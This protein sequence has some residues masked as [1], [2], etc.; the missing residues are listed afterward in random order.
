MTENEEKSE[1]KIALSL[2]KTAF[3]TLERDFQEVLMELAGKD[4]L[5]KFKGEYEK[6]HRTLL[7]AHENEKRLMK[8]CE[9]LT[10]EII[11]NA[12]K[13]QTA[14]NLSKED[15]NTISILKRE[16]DK[17]WKLIN[18][19][20]EKEASAKLTIQKL[21]K[22]I[23]EL[24]K[25]VN[26]GGNNSTQDGAVFELEKAKKDLTKERDQKIQQI[27]SLTN[28]M[29]NLQI[30]INDFNQEKKKYMITIESLTDQLN[31][32]RAK[33][34]QL[35]KQKEKSDRELKESKQLLSNKNQELGKKEIEIR[36]EQ[37]KVIEA[38]KRIKELETHVVN[39]QKKIEQLNS[40]LEQSL[41]EKDLTERAVENLKGDFDKF[42]I[43][44]K[45]LENKIKEI[46]EEKNQLHQTYQSLMKKKKIVELERDEI[47]RSKSSLGEEINRL[48]KMIEE[49]KKEKEEELENVDK[50]T[51]EKNYLSKSL[52][53]LRKEKT[54]KQD[55]IKV[56][57]GNN[58]V[59]SNEVVEERK[60]TEKYRQ[61]TYSLEKE[62]EKYATDAA[63]AEQRYKM[64]L[65]EVKIKTMEC[66]ELQKKIVDIQD[67]LKQQQTLYETIRSERNAKSK[68]LIAAYEESEDM[69]K[70]FKVMQQQIDQLK[71]EITSR[72]K[73]LAS[74]MLHAKEKEKE[75]DKKMEEV[76]LLEKKH[77]EQAQVL[78]AHE[79]ENY[80][81]TQ[82][83]LQSDNERKKQKKDY[84]AV[85]S[86]R[87]VL[88]TQLIRRND[89]IAL[90]YEK[91][92]LQNSTL[93]K[94]AVQ[95]R[96]RLND[97]RMLKLKIKDLT[98]QLQVLKRHIKK[99]STF[100]S[101][102]HQLKRQIIEER[103]K[104][105][106]LSEELQNP[107]NVHRWRKLEGSDPT[108]FEL[109]LK[110]Q[111]LQKRLIEKTEEVME[112]DLIIKEKEEMNK[113]LKVILQRQPGPEVAEQLNIFQE[114]LR[115]KNNQIKTLA[116]EINY[117]HYKDKQQDYEKER[118]TRELNDTKKKFFA[119]KKKENESRS[120]SQQEDIK[121]ASSDLRFMGGGFSLN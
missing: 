76:K 34:D 32:Q 5:E 21:T 52:V 42:Q 108:Q 110:T 57:E 116:A 75:K 15:Q 89:E 98:R 69:K 103:N 19:S 38:E 30:T 109:V 53:L 39:Q 112:K 113:K 50:L 99:F 105:K 81:L 119:V 68:A 7:R 87:D 59:L 20:H 28:E 101:E 93:D 43:E 62:R 100:Q 37:T 86:E 104:V 12:S 74:A 33:Y 117:L 1:D 120:S 45:L 2:S 23:S 97:I 24:S 36:K 46:T 114:T 88:G 58:K 92:Q 10:Q 18:A 17:A 66:N 91:I 111:T 72:E 40:Q 65:E 102:N 31:D 6:L 44:K 3:E 41:I 94:G 16:I 63:E 64:A 71:E 83:I 27:I 107:M 118:I 47:E 79:L 49:I 11:A 13:V 60:Q 84:E 70:Q 73:A 96:E 9:E 121:V 26:Q 77:E 90:L 67:K 56:L 85:V 61:M 115:K 8:K 55:N 54:N 25:L 22:E 106:A 80:R 48:N 4:H 51:A 14:I 29:T 82:I 95:Y 35:Y 78:K